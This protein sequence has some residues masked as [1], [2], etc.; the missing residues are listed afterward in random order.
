M[1][2]RYALEIDTRSVRS[3]IHM[4]AADYNKDMRFVP[5]HNRADDTYPTFPR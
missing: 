1:I 3:M 2:S 5:V 4:Y